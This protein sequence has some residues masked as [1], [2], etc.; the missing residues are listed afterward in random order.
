[1]WSS[2]IGRSSAS[3]AHAASLIEGAL[4][5]AEFVADVVVCR[6]AEHRPLYRQAQILARHGAP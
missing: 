2:R 4:P 3:V 5:S 6:L 1:M